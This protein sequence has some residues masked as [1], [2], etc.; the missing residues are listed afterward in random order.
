[1]LFKQIK[2]VLTQTQQRASSQW[3]CSTH[4]VPHGQTLWLQ[5]HSGQVL[6]VREGHV[7]AVPALGHAANVDARWAMSV[8]PAAA[9]LRG[10][11]VLLHA[12]CHTTWLCLSA[13]G[14]SDAVLELWRPLD[15]S[16]HWHQRLMHGAAWLRKQI[17]GTW[18]LQSTRNAP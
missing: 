7:R 6:R 14:A 1:M 8:A 5:L 16:H 10:S 9:P 17:K 4:R 15:L 18:L 12:A 2:A 3:R 11:H 13:E